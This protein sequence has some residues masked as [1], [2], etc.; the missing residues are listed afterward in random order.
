M[1][2]SRAQD[3][4]DRQEPRSENRSM[5]RLK[6]GPS[7]NV[8]GVADDGVK[9]FYGDGLVV[10]LDSNHRVLEITGDGC[11]VILSKNSGRVRI[12]GDG[13][14]LRVNHNVGD[15]EYTGDGGQVL[16]G[17]DSSK[18]KVRFVGDGGKVIF[19]LGA[20]AAEPTTDYVKFHCQ[21]R[22]L[23]EPPKDRRNKEAAHEKCEGRHNGDDGCWRVT[24]SSSSRER[25]DNALNEMKDSGCQGKYSECDDQTRKSSRRQ[26]V[27]VTKIVTKIPGDG[28]C[29]R[30]RLNDDSSLLVNWT[31]VKSSSRDRRAC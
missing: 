14:R 7:E 6:H 26:V 15:I 9:R 28:R 22:R 5:R 10:R 29:V 20:E 2:I 1:T 17:P 23:K 19:D 12:V 13:C 8:G 30:K 3:Q 27:T 21:R 4:F 31:D 18:E 16:L 11:R 24:M 25:L